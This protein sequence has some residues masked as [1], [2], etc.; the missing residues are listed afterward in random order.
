VEVQ[1]AKFRD[2]QYSGWHFVIV[3]DIKERY[4]LFSSGSSIC[5]F[6]GGGGTAQTARR[7]WLRGFP[8]K[9]VIVVSR[10]QRPNGLVGGKIAQ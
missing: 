6:F 2:W 9:I 1:L 3:I 4:I 8:H 5:T 7:P 10:Q